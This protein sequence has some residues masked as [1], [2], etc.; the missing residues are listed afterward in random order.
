MDGHAKSACHHVIAMTCCRFIDINTSNYKHDHYRG[1]R[2][3]NAIGRQYVLGISSSRQDHVVHAC[4]P[5]P[6]TFWQKPFVQE[7]PHR[8]GFHRAGDRPSFH[9]SNGFIFEW[10]SSVSYNSRIDPLPSRSSTLSSARQLLPE[11]SRLSAV[12]MHAAPMHSADPSACR[13]PRRS[14]SMAWLTPLVPLIALYWVLAHI[15]A[16][17]ITL[18]VIPS[19]LLAKR[20]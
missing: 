15:M 14:S 20:L 3:W 8:Y 17:A 13:P 1:G 18:T 19:Y 9:R 11:H 10:S 16:W 12:A 4:L 5:L 6:H 7:W 2:I